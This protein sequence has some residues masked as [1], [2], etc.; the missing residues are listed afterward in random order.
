M[1]GF[2]FLIST[3]VVGM[4][5]TFYSANNCVMNTYSVQATLQNF[6]YIWWVDSTL[7]WSSREEM[8]EPASVLV[9]GCEGRNKT[10][11]GRA[12]FRC[13]GTLHC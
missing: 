2:A 7:D 5:G 13:G 10:V 3:A 9:C 6:L 11:K 1:W 12:V 8:R 4:L